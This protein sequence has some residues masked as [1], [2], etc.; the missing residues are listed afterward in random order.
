MSVTALIMIIYVLVI[1]P[2]K[3]KIMVVLTAA[4]EAM[5]LVLHLISVAFLDETMSEAKSNQLGW[6]VIAL[7]GLYILVNWVVVLTFTVKDLCKKRKLKKVDKQKQKEKEK[8]DHE[9]KKWKKKN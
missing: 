4:G 2:Q 6:F 7:V 3:D 5:L 8:K 9:Y 1:K